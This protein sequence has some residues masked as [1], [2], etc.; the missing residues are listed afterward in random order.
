MSS[1]VS[2]VCA[3]QWHSCGDKPGTSLCSVGGLS[4]GELS[5][6]DS[7]QDVLLHLRYFHTADEFVTNY[8]Y[9]S[10]WLLQPLFDDNDSAVD[11]ALNDNWLPLLHV[12]QSLDIFTGQLNC[13]ASYR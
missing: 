9:P 6:V 5:L 10:V 1:Y 3:H 2:C 7:Q 4:V 12:L 13:T 11:W 8:D